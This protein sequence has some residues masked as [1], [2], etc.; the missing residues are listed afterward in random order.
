MRPQPGSEPTSPDASSGLGAL[1]ILSNAPRFWRSLDEL[2]GS[3]VAEE[4]CMGSVDA[5]AAVTGLATAEG[6]VC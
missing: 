2:A 1:P 6:A 5:Y 4:R 3:G